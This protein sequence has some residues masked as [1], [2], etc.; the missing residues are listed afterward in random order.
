MGNQIDLSRQIIYTE[1]QIVSIINRVIERGIDDIV[2]PIDDYSVLIEKIEFKNALITELYEVY[3][4]PKRHEFELE[5]LSEIVEAIVNSKITIFIAGAAATG[6]I[7]NTFTDLVK[8]LLSKIIERFKSMPNESQKFK[9]LFTDV[10]KVEAFFK[11]NNK[12]EINKLERELDI[13]KTRLVPILKL[14]GFKTY[15]EKNKRYWE[16]N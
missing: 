5:L 15:K 6:L 11:T 9:T 10:E 14:L 8:K 7:G 3:F 2:E 13:D 4:P 1:N 16:K 12:A